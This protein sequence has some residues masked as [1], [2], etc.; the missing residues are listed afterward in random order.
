MRVYIV[1]HKKELVADMVRF[2][3]TGQNGLPDEVVPAPGPS[4]TGGGNGPGNSGGG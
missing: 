2:V 1:S 3:E 4:S